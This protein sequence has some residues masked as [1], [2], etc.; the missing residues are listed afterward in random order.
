[1]DKRVGA[2][3]ALKQQRRRDLSDQGGFLSQLLK[4]SG[5]VPATSR[6]R[7]SK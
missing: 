1:M 3:I 2:N 4:S 6:Y 5:G 7:F